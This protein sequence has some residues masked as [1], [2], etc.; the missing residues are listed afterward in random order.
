MAHHIVYIPN[1]L[2]A[3]LETGDELIDIRDHLQHMNWLTEGLVYKITHF[4]MQHD[5][6]DPETGGRD[7]TNFAENC[8]KLFPEGHIFAS[9]G[10]TK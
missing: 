9:E 10:Q 5:D 3:E 2:E 8:M 6:I 4:P 7:R 1:F